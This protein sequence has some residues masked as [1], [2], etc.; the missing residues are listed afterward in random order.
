MRSLFFDLAIFK[1]E[2]KRIKNPPK[3]NSEADKEFTSKLDKPEK[4]H[5]TLTKS[6]EQTKGEQNKRESQRQSSRKKRHAV[7]AK[8]QKLNQG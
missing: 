7:L 6:V 8:P 1:S 3:A 4:R 5:Q 2:K